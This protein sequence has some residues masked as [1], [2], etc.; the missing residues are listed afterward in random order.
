MARVSF[1]ADWLITI[2]PIMTD[3]SDTSHERWTLLL[4]EAKEWYDHYGA[5]S[6]AHQSW[7][8]V[9][10][11][12]K[13]IDEEESSYEWVE[14][15]ENNDTQSGL[16]GAVAI[17]MSAGV[18]EKTVFLKQL[19]DPTEAVTVQS[20]VSILRRW[21]RWSLG[22]V[23]ALVG[24]LLAEA[25]LLLRL[26]IIFLGPGSPSLRRQAILQELVLSLQSGFMSALLVVLTLTLHFLPRG[27]G[28][29]RSA[30]TMIL[31]WRCWEATVAPFWWWR[32]RRMG[33]T[34]AHLL[35]VIALLNCS[36]NLRF[37]LL[38]SLLMMG[39][40][41]YMG[42]RIALELFVGERTSVLV[43][44]WRFLESSVEQLAQ[45][46]RR[47]LR[48]APNVIYV[49]SPEEL[50]KEP[51]R[52]EIGL[53]FGGLF[54]DWLAQLALGLFDS[55]NGLVEHS[56]VDGTCYARLKPGADLKHLEA[57]GKV[58]GLA[59]RDQQPL[60]VEICPPL[61]H[62]LA[63]PT[64]PRALQ[65]ISKETAEQ[66]AD[67][68]CL[69]IGDQLRTPAGGGELR[70]LGFSAE[71]LRWVSQEE[72]DFWRRAQR[73]PVESELDHVDYQG[74]RSAEGLREHMERKALS[75]LVLD[76]STELE[77]V[78][79]GLRSVP[80]VSLPSLDR[81]VKRGLEEEDV[82]CSRPSK[83]RRLERSVLQG[84]IS[85]GPDVPL[86]VWQAVTRYTPYEA[87]RAIEGQRTVSWF[88]DYVASLDCEQ[89]SGL[90]QWITGYRRIPP[91]GFPSPVPY[92]TLHL[93]NVG[94]ERLPTAHT[95]GLQL[96]L[97]R[98][99][100]TAQMLA[101]RLSHASAERQ[102]HL[103]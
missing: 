103:V 15:E 53:D 39:P 4:K 99:Y 10:P 80:N 88:W 59:L 61:A 26:L 56:C 5:D 38:T 28:V 65:Q 48:F 42:C 57:M 94:P 21:T 91:G 70:R 62:L 2:E 30:V 96:D 68:D 25:T 69:E 16:A 52:Q 90:L 93:A 79:R 83:R 82:T 19:E 6:A 78:W 84:L 81:E 71:W 33:M 31:C 55:S 14:V 8:L 22:L 64:L 58:L 47:Q 32:A 12:R 37:D 92:M 75:S 29:L 85:G 97:P 23:H 40:G 72:Y 34:A 49:S 44:R 76:V 86:T 98:S 60:G 102:F 3:M 43:Q 54:R 95:C 18:Y 11:K 67:R 1:F 20:G 45:L 66:T 36:K 51:G 24:H 9:P 41:A 50:G 46:T 13:I 87:T 100:V 35:V 27:A 63:H 77:Y 7:S 17:L 89:R 74:T 101:E 73:T